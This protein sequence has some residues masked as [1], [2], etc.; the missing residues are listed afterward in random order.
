MNKWHM[1]NILSLLLVLTLCG[2]VSE[3]PTLITESPTPPSA[4][5]ATDPVPSSTPILTP[6]PE[7]TATSLPFLMGA[8]SSSVLLPPAYF[9]GAVV[10]TQYYTLMDHGFGDESLTL[11]S[12]SLY[13]MVQGTPEPNIQSIKIDYLEPYPLTEIKNKYPPQTIPENELRFHVRYTV[14]YKGA[15]W[16]TGGTPTPYQKRNFI[17]LIKENGE[18]KIDKINSSPWYPSK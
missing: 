16:N 9:D 14:I 12:R 8:G 10:I 1:V 4:I 11:F 7:P 18:W 5:K 17:S 3:K 15:A 13:K 6:E 2:C